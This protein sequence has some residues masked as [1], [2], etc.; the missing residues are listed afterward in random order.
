LF[1]PT[2]RDKS[3]LENLKL[4]ERE[5]GKKGKREK[6]EKGKRGKGEKGKKQGFLSISLFTP[7]PFSPLPAIFSYLRAFRR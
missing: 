4:I 2:F 1:P 3:R 7:F 5:R 6:G